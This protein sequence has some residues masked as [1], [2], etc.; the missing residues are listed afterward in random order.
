MSKLEIE[1][2]E[3]KKGLGLMLFD[4]IGGDAEIEAVTLLIDKEMGSIFTDNKSALFIL[5]SL[6]K[7]LNDLKGNAKETKETVT[8][9]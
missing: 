5:Q 1:I 2:P 6:L 3:D 4:V 7:R 8:G 9:E